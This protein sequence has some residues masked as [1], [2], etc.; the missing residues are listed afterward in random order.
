MILRLALRNSLRNRRRTLLTAVAIAAGFALLI[1]FMGMGDGAHEKMAEIGVSM[2]LGD[3]VVHAQ[4]YADDPTLD[5]LIRD[6]RPVA[7]SIARMPG[8]VHVAPRLRT[9]ALITSGATSVGV[10]LSGVDPAVEHLVSRID[11]QAS[12]IAGSTLPQS[13]GPRPKS[14]LPPVVIGKQLAKTLGVELGDRVTL[15]LRPAGGGETRSGAYEVHG[16]FAT[17]VA[18]IDAFWAEIPLDDAQRLAATGN[19]VSMLAVILDNISESALAA[20]HIESALSGK[21]VEVLPWAEAAPDLYAIIAVDEGGMYVMMI[22]VFIVVAAGI[23]NALL[24][25]VMER[26]REFGVLLSLGTTPSR[27]VAIVMS[28]AFVLGVVSLV[29][30]LA[31]GLIGN[32]HY[33]TA[34]IDVAGWVGSGMET[35][36]IVLPKRF[37]SHLYPDK[38]LWSSLIVLGLVMLGAIY[39][40][41]RAARLEPVEALRHE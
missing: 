36:G 27:V 6:P 14:Q 23:L 35:S 40:A 26:T 5:R 4:G 28:E 8:V 3:V 37:Y 10:A 1:V 32:H 2:G 29:I 11:T 20:K 18:E 21:D 33:A 13:H 19:G 25:S 24:M 16:I 9:D 41:L 7:D 15:T 17:G 39:P 30:G 12:M 22:I 31:F 38:V 34:G